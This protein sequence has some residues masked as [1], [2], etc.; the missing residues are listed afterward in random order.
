MT[1]PTVT[2]RGQVWRDPR[3]GRAWAA[4]AAAIVAR[5]LGICWRCGHEGA[6]TAGHV[7]PWIKRPDLGLDPSNVRAEHGKR[8][9]LAVDGFECP[10]NFASGQAETRPD[11]T[12][13]RTW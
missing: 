8:H 11:H 4:F 9:T 10:G 7:I 2:Y 3:Q 12:E 5:D 13:R 6:E 1:K